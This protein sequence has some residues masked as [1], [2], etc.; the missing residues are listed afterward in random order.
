MVITLI[1]GNKV[2]ENSYRWSSHNGW[3]KCLIEVPIMTLKSI[4]VTIY[5]LLTISFLMLKF[6]LFL[7]I[8]LPAAV[9]MITRV[10]KTAKSG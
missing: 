2:Q 5:N 8:I 7:V 3:K 1:D 6:V 9:M 10:Q 4:K